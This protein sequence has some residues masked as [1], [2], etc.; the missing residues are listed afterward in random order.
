MTLSEDFSIHSPVIRNAPDH[1]GLR[2][3][4]Y[5]VLLGSMHSEEKFQ[6][7]A[8]IYEKFKAD[9]PE[10]YQEWLRTAKSKKL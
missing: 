10:I 6:E 5:G 3:V 7:R 9:N 4:F 1:K 8:A 2:E